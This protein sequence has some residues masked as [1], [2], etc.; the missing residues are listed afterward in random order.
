[1]PTVD[2]LCYGTDEIDDNL[3]LIIRNKSDITP[4]K[5][6]LFTKIYQ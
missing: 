4:P 2:F 1:M 3:K 5:K 6:K